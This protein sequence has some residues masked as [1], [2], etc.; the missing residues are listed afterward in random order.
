MSLPQVLRNLFP[1]TIS[2]S[3]VVWPTFGQDFPSAAEPSMENLAQRIIGETGSTLERT[4]RL[5]SWINTSLSWTATDYGKRTPEEII[6]RGAGNCHELASVLERLCQASNIRYRW[7]AEINLQP[8]SSDRE[9]S[10]NQLIRKIGPKGSVFGFRHNDHRWLEVY[11]EGTNT[12]F[13]ADPATGVVGM[14]PWIEARI[15]LGNRPIPPVPAVAQIMRDMIV[16]F[17]I[18]ALPART[19]T[20]G[21]DRSSYYLID[22]LNH[23]YNGKLATLPSWPE[24][25][26]LVMRL[27]RAGALAFSGNADLHEQEQSIEQ[28]A[29]VYAQLKKE[30]KEHGLL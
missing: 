7:I 23:F 11:D 16:P 8:E 25:V 30:A 9:D 12:W 10:A 27:S 20:Q 18:I 22:A 24:W 15:S 6:Q 13:P 29:T 3:V 28:F 2:L 19:A 26:Q 17:T 5:V 21:E 14:R 4:Q 1:I